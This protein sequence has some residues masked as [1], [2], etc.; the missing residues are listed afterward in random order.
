M[1]K[2]QNYKNLLN[3]LIEQEELARGYEPNKSYSPSE[4]FEIKAKCEK[5]IQEMEKNEDPFLENFNID[6]KTHI[7]DTNNQTKID[8]KSNYNIALKDVTKEE[9]KFK[10]K[11]NKLHNKLKDDLKKFDRQFQRDFGRITR[12]SGVRNIGGSAASSGSFGKIFGTASNIVSSVFGL[13]GSLLSGASS[14]IGSGISLIGGGLGTLSSFIPGVGGFSNIALSLLGKGAGGLFSSLGG[15]GGMALGGMGSLL[16]G[17]IGLLGSALSMPGN[18]LGGSSFA[19]LIGILSIIQNISKY[20]KG[21]RFKGVEKFFTGGF[22]L[23]NMKNMSLDDILD[24]TSGLGGILTMFPETSGFG[25]SLLFTSEIARYVKSKWDDILGYTKSLFSKLFNISDKE[26]ND[27]IEKVQTIFNWIHINYP[28]IKEKFFG[29]LNKIKTIYSY[30]KKLFFSVKGFVENPKEQLQ[31]LL[32]TFFGGT[33]YYGVTYSTAAIEKIYDGLKWIQKNIIWEANPIKSMTGPNGETFK[34]AEDYVKEKMPEGTIEHFFKKS[35]PAFGNFMEKVLDIFSP[36][37]AGAAVIP[38]GYFKKEPTQTLFN[39]I[40]TFNNVNYTVDQETKS[41]A[42]PISS[43]KTA[44]DIPTTDL[45]IGNMRAK[46]GF[47]KF[48]SAEEGIAGMVQLLGYKKD[49]GK[50]RYNQKSIREIGYIWAP[51]ED[52]N[53]TENWIKVVSKVSGFDPN[54]KLDLQ[55]PD[56]LERI[57]NGIGTI[58]KGSKKMKS[59]SKETISKG[60]EMGLS[61]KSYDKFEMKSGTQAPS[62]MEDLYSLFSNMFN[63]LTKQNFVDS[64]MVDLKSNITPTAQQVEDYNKIMDLPQNQNGITKKVIEGIFNPLA[65]ALNNNLRNVS[66]EITNL[67]VNYFKMNDAKSNT[68]SE[69]DSMETLVTSILTFMQ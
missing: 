56:I 54:Q 22:S 68:P 60:I 58:E 20:K 40:S 16:G 48:S 65:E 64:L 30:S 67:N 4:Y 46:T 35:I 11:I 14:F 57:I 12:I 53:D 7:K 5:Q 2:N 10:T 66:S 49:K 34:D 44:S 25:I 51:P 8:E 39:N 27:G 36:K 15:L 3:Y 52:H 28:K 13:S 61:G 43:E 62:M 32:G 23:E 38:Q 41:Q 9:Y 1:E 63:G 24:A 19:P 18:L 26:L 47:Q 33:V 21:K 37:E 45:N 17:G 50:Y 59:I 42:A 55:N 69:I 31:T 29:Y 6:T